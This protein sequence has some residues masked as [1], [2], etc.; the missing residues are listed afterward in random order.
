VDFFDLKNISERY[1]ELVNPITAEKMLEIG[2]TV[3]LGENSRVIDFGCGFG[4]MLAL[5]ARNF[6]ISGIG[7]DVREYACERAR[8][9][10]EQ[11]GLSDRIQIIC[12]NAAEYRFQEHYFDV[13]AC[14]GA[15]FIWGG[16]RP[17]IRRMRDAPQPNGKIIVGESYWLKEPVPHEFAEKQSVYREHELLEMIRQE[18]FDL[19]HLVRA[20]HDDWDR[21]EAGNW[22]G[23]L[24]WLDE[25]PEHPQRH[26]VIKHLRESQGE[27]LRYGR[28]YMGWTMY[29]LGGGH[30]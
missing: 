4:E 2:R 18:K 7:V 29:V 8:K 3:D 17:A 1:M 14:I 20:N 11:Q 5:W 27:Y 26:E 13:A 30:S 6:R 21:Y 15:T 22:K 12:S 19:E 16:F 10:M 25:N 28:E 24:S 9:K 23:L